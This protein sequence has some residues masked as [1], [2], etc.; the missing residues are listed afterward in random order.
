MSDFCLVRGGAPHASLGVSYGTG[1]QY[2]APSSQGPYRHHCD[3]FTVG[4]ADTAKLGNDIG[5]WCRPVLRRVKNRV[6]NVEPRH[7][8]DIEPHAEHELKCFVQI[9]IDKLHDVNIT[10]LLFIFQ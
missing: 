5:I 10:S 3:V 4:W 1:Q 7:K 2:F 9:F 6:Y 8:P